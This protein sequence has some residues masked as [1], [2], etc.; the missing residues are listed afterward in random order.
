M[1]KQS[2][3][4]LSQENSFVLKYR[5]F[6]VVIVVDIFRQQILFAYFKLLV[7][8][9]RL[10]ETEHKYPGEMS[11]ADAEDSLDLMDDMLEIVK[12]E[13]AIAKV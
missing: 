6:S 11:L 7:Q 2:S 3:L 13:I 12:L 4:P 1:V 8:L 9:T 5:G 10:L